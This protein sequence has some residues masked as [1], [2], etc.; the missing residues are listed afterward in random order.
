MATREEKQKIMDQLATR[1]DESSALVLMGFEGMDM[2]MISQIRN[3]LR[4][5]D[6]SVHLY[7]NTY[8]SRVLESKGVQFPEET[9]KGQTAVLFVKGDV[10]GAAK[11]IVSAYKTIE[12]TAIKGGYLDGSVLSLDQIK[13]LSKLPGKDILIG[14]FVSG[15]AAPIGGF[16]SQLQAPVRGF[17]YGLQAIINNSK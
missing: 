12:S 9:L 2:L 11:L 5:L 16:V 13:V 7:K 3:S 10:A 14:Q 6:S 1:Y 17:I 15:L 8:L 4:D